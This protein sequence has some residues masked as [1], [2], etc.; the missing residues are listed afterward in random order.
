MKIKMLSAA[1]VAMLIST[2]S[3]EAQA[4]SGKATVLN[5]Y[6][7]DG[8]PDI[9]VIESPETVQDRLMTAVLAMEAGN[10]TAALDSIRILAALDTTNDAIYYYRGKCLQYMEMT[11]L[12]TPEVMK[13]FGMSPEADY[14]KAIALD[15]TNTNYYDALTN[16]LEAEDRPFEA[17]QIY[18]Y[19]IQ[20]FP[21]KYRNT[22][23]L[24]SL[25]DVA[26]YFSNDSLAVRYY[27]QAL[28]ID[29]EYAPATL[30]LAE[31]Y[32]AQGNVPA[33]FTHM[34]EF[35]Q[36]SYIDPQTKCDY[37]DRV[38]KTIDGRFYRA[39]HVQL[40][41]LVAGI[42]NAHPT[43]SVALKYAGR[44]FY[45]TEQEEKG[46]SYFDRYVQCYPRSIEAHKLKQSLCYVQKD[47]DG[48]REEALKIINLASDEGDTEAIADQYTL[49][50]DMYHEVGR[51]KDCY[52]CYNAAL[53]LNPNDATALNNYA[54]YI[55]TEKHG[56]STL[57]LGSRTKRLN[58]A[59]EMSR[60]AVE[61]EP[62]NASYLDTYGWALHLLGKNE[63][64]KIQFKRAMM[65]GGKDSAVVLYHYSIVLRDLGDTKLAD[66]Y[67]GLAKDKLEEEKDK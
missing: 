46:I 32:F 1:V 35:V 39:W 26:Q 24:T 37:V 2:L 43:D 61:S 54:Y 51:Y 66:Y 4:P 55:L 38:I 56:L 3:V 57:L 27:Q 13:S 64:A 67:Y 47:Y 5:V 65:Y 34:G 7:P 8:N 21:N 29:P 63:D 15:S 28:A 42:P 48:V 31:S 52:W 18:D 45:G 11:G 20:R 16:L 33:F 10:Y 53:E 22:Y 62:D 17:A 49:L 23:V 60:K 9:T 50:G 14:R 41:S 12:V 44:W 19:L 6:G 36:N 58:R 59:A 25:A 40:D 30:G